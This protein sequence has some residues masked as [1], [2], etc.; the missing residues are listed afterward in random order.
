METYK[1]GQGSFARLT[2]A[3]CLLVV[4]FLGCVELYGWIQDTSDKPLLP[5]EVFKS[6]PV[7]NTPLSWKFLLCVAIFVGAAWFV[8][9][10]LSKPATVD[11][12]IETE[13]EM[14]KVSWPTREE[15]WNATGVV[16]LVTLLLTA[17]LFTFDFVLAKFFDLFF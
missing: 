10:L 14:K 6:L 17:S 16:V 2:A 8:R 3:V 11:A 13:L 1:S 7:L 9:R 12:L 4:A 15:S 5:S